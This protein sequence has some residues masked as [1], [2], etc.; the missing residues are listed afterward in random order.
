LPREKV[1]EILAKKGMARYTK[2]TI[3]EP[4]AFLKELEV[5]NERGYALDENEHEEGIRCIAAPVM[6][7]K[8]NI[9]AAISVVGPYGRITDDRLN[10]LIELT[11]QTAQK[12]SIRM[13]YQ[14]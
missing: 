7:F 13:G 5:V 8:G 4:L 14:G 3:T 10:S 1:L 6:D 9:V 11:T 2:D 12:I